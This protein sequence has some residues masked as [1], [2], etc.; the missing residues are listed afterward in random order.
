MRLLSF[1]TLIAV[2]VVCSGSVGSKSAAEQPDIS[3]SGSE[4][5]E[6]CS[7]A[8]GEHKGHPV[9]IQGG[10]T[11]LGWVEGFRDGFSVHDG[12][13]NREIRR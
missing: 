8:D 11:C 12:S 3:R 7:S 9:P 5:L 1:L 4:F 2:C 10:A 13:R 6:V